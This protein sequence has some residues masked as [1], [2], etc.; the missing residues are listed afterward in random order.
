[1]AFTQRAS[2]ANATT[3][4]PAPA[5]VAAPPKD[6][7]KTKSG[8]AS[9]VLKDLGYDNVTNLQGGFQKWAQSGLPVAK[10][11]ADLVAYLQSVMK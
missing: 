6:A 3:P 7:A 11:R 5:D 2:S 1:M 8:L 4:P 10:D 9:K